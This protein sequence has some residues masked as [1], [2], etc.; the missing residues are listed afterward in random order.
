MIRYIHPTATRH[1]GRGV[2][3]AEKIESDS[4]GA[5]ERRSLVYNILAL[6]PDVTDDGLGWQGFAMLPADEQRQTSLSGFSVL[7]VLDVDE[8]FGAAQVVSD[9]T[10]LYIFRPD[11]HAL[12]VERFLLVERPD[13]NARDGRGLALVA[14]W[15]VR[16]RRS[17]SP[18]LPKS[19]TD[20]SGYKNPDGTPFLDPR[21]YLSLSS[22]VAGSELDL[23]L[24]FS[25]MLLP[26]AEPGRLQWRLFARNGGGDRL[27]SYAVPRLSDGWFDL[28]AATLD[29]QGRV[30][31]LNSLMPVLETQEGNKPLAFTGQP[32]ATLYQ[33]LEPMASA[34]GGSVQMRTANRILLACPASLRASESD[35]GA[36]AEDARL[37]TF[38]FEV[39]SSG[40]VAYDGQFDQ[41]IEVGETG[42]DSLSVEF[43]LPSYASIDNGVAGSAQ[44]SLQLW[45]NPQ[46]GPVGA[47]EAGQPRSILSQSGDAAPEQRGL[48][49]DIVEQFRIRLRYGTGAEAV[50]A[51][52]RGNVLS[53][54]SWS[55]ISVVGDGK[56]LA[57][58]LNGNE[59]AVDTVGTPAA[60][61]VGKIDLIGAAQGGFLGQITETRIWSRALSAAEIQA[62]IF[63][64]LSE[65]KP[66]EGVLAYWPMDGGTGTSIADASGNGHDAAMHGAVWSEGTAP[67]ARKL[68]PINQIDAGNRGLSAGW[69]KPSQVYPQFGPVQ[70]DSRPH[71]LATGDGPIHLYF[72]GLQRRFCVAR[73]SA[74]AQR[75]FFT[76]SWSARKGDGSV[77]ENGRMVF[78]TRQTGAYNSFTQIA[79]AAGASA[80]SCDVSIDGP[81]DSAPNASALLRRFARA[82]STVKETWSGVPRR[83]GYFEPILNGRAVS[84]P[85]DPRIAAG[86]AVFYDYAGQRAQALL[87]LSPE[88]GLAGLRFVSALP[89]DFALSELRGT[90][91]GGEVALHLQFKGAGDAPIRVRLGSVPRAPEAIVDL[92]RGR[93]AEA[94]YAGNE[95]STSAWALPSGGTH[96][97]VLAPRVDNGVPVVRGAVFRLSAG[98]DSSKA[99]F[100]AELQLQGQP[101]LKAT[102]S[103]VPRRG[104]EFIKALRAGT[105]PEQKLV[106]AELEFL[107]QTQGDSLNADNVIVDAQANL[108]YATA[109]LAVVREGA[110]GDLPNEFDLRCGTLQGVAGPVVAPEASVASALVSV[111][112]LSLP[113][114]GYPAA[115]SL[116]GT[117]DGAIVLATPG[118][119]GGWLR[120]PPRYAQSFDGKGALSVDLAKLAPAADVYDVPG[121]VTIEAWVLPDE[122]QRAKTRDSE[123]LQSML[124]YSSTQRGLSYSLGYV[125]VETPR[126][127]EQ[128]QFSLTDLAV[129]ATRPA[130][131]LVR[132]QKYTVQMYLRPVLL[133]VG[134]G[135]FWQ[136]QA[137][138]GSGD[139]ERLSIRIPAAQGDDAD[140]APANWRVVFSAGA[141]ELE[142]TRALEGN[143]WTLVSLVR[144][145][146]SVRLYVD[147]E[148][149]AQHDDIAQPA[150]ASNRYTV[151]NPANNAFF[152][153]EPNEFAAWNQTR[154]AQEIRAGYLRPL[155]GAEPGLAALYPLSRPEANYQLT[156]RARWTTTIYNT[157][158][159][160]K[161]FFTKT[162][163]FF[164]LVASYGG[165]AS[166]T[167]TP[168]LAPHRWLHV[169]AVL[170]RR[171]ALNLRNRASAAA[172]GNREVELSNSFSVDARIR[173]SALEKSR[174]VIVGRFDAAANA[175]VYELGVRQDGRAYATV[176]LRPLA[177]GRLS[178]PD[179]GL[180]TLLADQI[181]DAQAPHHIA[182]SLSL[183]TVN[184]SVSR[185]EVTALAGDV[186]VDGVGNERILAPVDADLGLYRFVRVIGGTGSGYYRSGDWVVIEAIEST[187]FT[188]WYGPIG[189]L[190]G[191]KPGDRKVSFRM[192]QGDKFTDRTIAADAFIDAVEFARA[193]TPTRV[194]VSG[195]GASADGH[196]GGQ[197]S[198]VRVWNESLSAEQV[199]ELAAQPGAS[200]FDDKL[201][202]W[203][204]FS[205]QSGRLAKDRVGSNDLT[206]TSSMSW[207]WFDGASVSFYL[208][209]QALP[210]V[211]L[212]TPAYTD[213]PRQMRIGGLANRDGN[214]AAG[215]LGKLD[216]LRL[217][218]GPRTREQILINMSRYQTGAEPGLAGYWR[219]D[220]GSGRIVADRTVHRGDG[221]YFNDQGQSAPIAW[222]ASSAPVGFDAPIVN[223]VLDTRDS[224]EAVELGALPAS[225]A[226]FE[227]GD[228]LRLADGSAQ[229]VL[230]RSYIFDGI[231][232]LDDYT[233]Y[234]V[235]DLE[236]I[237]I[238]Q[239]QTDPT[240]VGF[241][242][243]APPLPSE[244]LTRP[245]TGPSDVDTYNG[246]SA[247]T[248]TDEQSQTVAL[249]A[250][251][252]VSN[253]T[254]FKLSVGG[255]GTAEKDEV[256]GIPPIQ[257]AVKTVQFQLKLGVQVSGSF[258]TS[259][260]VERGVSSGAQRSITQ[261]LANGGQWEGKNPE[262]GYFLESGERRFVPGNVGSA[263][264][265]SQVADLYALRVPSTGALVSMSAEAN[266]EIPLDINII[267]FPIDPSYQLAG[268]LDGQI[269]L[270]KAPGTERSYYKPREAYTL[271]R[272]VE[273]QR[274][275]QVA[276]YEQTDLQ[277]QLDL[278]ADLG[279]AAARNPAF[280][281][282]LTAPVR[283]MVNTYVWSADGGTYAESEGFS[284]E[285]TESFSV[286]RSVEIGV[287]FN[288]SVFFTLFGG[289]V[290]IDGE[291]GS[292][293]TTGFS[294]TK[295]LSRERALKL[296]VEAEPDPLPFRYDEDDKLVEEAVPGKVDGYRFMSFFLANRSEHAASLFDQ[297]IDQHWLYSSQDPNAAAL[298]QARARRQGTAPWR[299][300][301]R[302]TYVSR[303]PPRFQAVPPLSDRGAEPEAP[304]QA[305]NAVFLSLVRA[306]LPAR[307][308]SAAEISAAVQAVLDSDTEAL[309]PWWA[310]FRQAARIANSPQQK[311]LAQITGD[312]IAYAISVIGA[313]A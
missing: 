139:A 101:A 89:R 84:D 85:N 211:G 307:G 117:G 294:A 224:P 63:E 183:V 143:R 290:S 20:V 8:S 254:Q 239:V 286:G 27:Y 242:E 25:A 22:G 268:S 274:Q 312:A 125:P 255:A 126:F 259:T 124:H 87:E 233:G 128:V 121:A 81:G 46:R 140:A 270:Q 35:S 138:D 177:G 59:V 190:E 113:Q 166:T 34:V 41:A 179:Q 160:G 175:Q 12:L 94:A 249:A 26:T 173:V 250:S 16:F 7:R 311:Q 82:K 248:L 37:S 212:K 240:V 31:P 120:D 38:D 131:K 227:Y 253:K 6:N 243:G 133:S 127:F 106:L 300:L 172:S 188:R 132:D 287:G 277:A 289:G 105:A 226:V 182:A 236:R 68:H 158:F 185:R 76:G 276:F 52:T 267:R 135:W 21:R 96:L 284:T 64:P 201:V 100:S 44:F 244:N 18:D 122:S 57:I 153:F 129:P 62:N 271:K 19:P 146:R 225:V 23:S 79:I 221:L 58:Y 83:L 134:T 230:K 65:Q 155:T 220:T 42:P 102:W 130:E 108:R 217:W 288:F 40:G 231:S 2:L 137:P 184:D 302:V 80:L 308:A 202:S 61:P 235:G 119:D 275:R 30:L 213:T 210:T 291:L 151:A 234:K 1:Q 48:T 193:S 150:M 298:R 118:R 159:A 241:I 32:A 299:V 215:L 165:R 66:V 162:G 263:L 279:A 194:G 9:E 33:R 191:F 112:A 257:T 99:E 136:R 206:L 103:D 5:V 293:L 156:N 75:A 78:I 205:E 90:A 152:E 116:G 216:E 260:G 71:A 147:G 273:R 265:K 297:V 218:R 178:S 176:R 168:A 192:P 197:I 281:A 228:T 301:H 141:H 232:G 163:L 60:A 195:R 187:R 164:D 95:A 306:K 262:G 45:L 72:S 49:L 167:L 74:Q 295:S 28:D 3:L 305:Q 10:H 237:Y 285:L 292:T 97:F 154:S 15:E 222:S 256:I 198:D 252:D 170:D 29:E 104:P 109:L 199:A 266:P 107:D 86:T 88:A 55:N 67:M 304:N 303:I 310:Q 92:L 157:K 313:A 4:Q 77:A 144:D 283:D 161:P 309:L 296:E 208:D 17:G 214:F 69:L 246:I 50:S 43:G 53:Y 123:T 204:S 11:R 272:E 56:R 115:V 73:M 174:Q 13:P 247:V 251:N 169:A 110:G 280:N 203:W 264:V 200:P 91:D 223:D 219:F 54:G 70:A 14:D 207:T 51:V 111:Q 148:L 181:V 142:S 245:L 180:V 196:F 24:G 39:D 145:G 209:G 261:R 93:A 98:S 114:M 269:G 238:G 47:E 189:D 278:G 282:D 186:F 229:G 36:D 171:G 149:A 258:E